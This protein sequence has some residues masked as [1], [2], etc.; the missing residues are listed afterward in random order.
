[1]SGGRMD[2]EAQASDNQRSPL[3]AWDV[4]QVERA[5]SSVDRAAAF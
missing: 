1:M 3:G 2:T 4:P 5:G